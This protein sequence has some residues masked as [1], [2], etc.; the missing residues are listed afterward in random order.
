[1]TCKR[2]RYRSI[3]TTDMTLPIPADASKPLPSKNGDCKP[4]EE[5]WPEVKL[6]SCI[7][8]LAQPSEID[9]TCPQCQ[10]KTKAQT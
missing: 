1:M 2:V 6:D 3:N 4:N 7:D 5:E 9:Y 8:L 10:T